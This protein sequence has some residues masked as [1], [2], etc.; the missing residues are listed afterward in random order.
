MKDTKIL[1]KC[2]LKNK[3]P[4]YFDFL[5][6]RVVSSMTLSYSDASGLKLLYDTIVPNSE[7]VLDFSSER[8]YELTSDLD[9][10]RSLLFDNSELCARYVS[11]L[12]S[13]LSSDLVKSEDYLAA[14][15]I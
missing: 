3:E 5:Y 11:A 13:D 10:I 14:L 7:G 1:L 8:K 4:Y 9:L 2:V 6:N 15:L 12:S